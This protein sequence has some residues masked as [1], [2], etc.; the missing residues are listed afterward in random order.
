MEGVGGIKRES[1]KKKK[2]EGNPQYARNKLCPGFILAL[3]GS[4]L[5]AGGVSSFSGLLLLRV[6]EKKWKKG[7][8]EYI[9]RF[10]WAVEKKANASISPRDL[11]TKPSAHRGPS[12][13]VLF[14]DLAWISLERGGVLIP[15][16]DEIIVCSDANW[17]IGIGKLE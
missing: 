9:H 7:G 2:D 5:W 16:I 14:A 11:R 3:H 15:R 10:P 4:L 13:S 12:S 1:E 6:L 17:R 8:W